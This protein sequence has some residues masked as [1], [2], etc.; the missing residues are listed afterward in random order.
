MGHGVPVQTTAGWGMV[1]SRPVPRLLTNQQEFC[2]GFG[3]AGACPGPQ[4]PAEG[5]DV[6]PGD[7]SERGLL[8]PVPTPQQGIEL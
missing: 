3:D 5:W 8:S 4:V 7:H 6:P 2:P 1:P